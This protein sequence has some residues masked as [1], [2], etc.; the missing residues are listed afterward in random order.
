MRETWQFTLSN[1]RFAFKVAH[2][3]SIGVRQQYPTL[4]LCNLLLAEAQKRSEYFSNR[5]RGVVACIFGRIAAQSPEL[6]IRSI[7]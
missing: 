3:I 6:T 4:L 1:I 7:R 2:V 5:L